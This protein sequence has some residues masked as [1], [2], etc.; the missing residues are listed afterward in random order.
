MSYTSINQKK[1]EFRKYLE[2]NGVVDSITKVLVSLYEEPERP[3]DPLELSI[4]I[5]CEYSYI[6]AIS[7][8]K[9]KIISF[10]YIFS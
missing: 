7:F 10:F 4:I 8:S 2:K 1:E 9:K 5:T 3:S 6:I